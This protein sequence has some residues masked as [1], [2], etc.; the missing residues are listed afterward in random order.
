MEF[1][2]WFCLLLIVYCYFGYPLFLLLVSKFT[3]KPVDKK[4]IM[5]KVSIVLSVWNEQDVIRRKLSNLMAL[6]YPADSYEIIVGSDGSDDNTN[7]IVRSFN[8]E[9]IRFVERA[10]RRGKMIVLNELVSLARH[11]IIVFN[12]ARQELPP[13]TIHKLVANFADS[14]VGCVSGELVFRKKEGATAQGINLYWE[15]EKFMRYHEAKIHSMLGATGAIYAIRKSLY[16]PVPKDVVLDDMYIPFRIIEQ[17]FRAVFEPLAKAYDDVAENPK[18]EARR[19]NRTLFGNFQIFQL[20]P[21]MFNPFESHIAIQ[22]FSHKFLRIAAPFLMVFLILL[23][24]TL[25]GRTFY[26]WTMF[27]QLLFYSMAVIGLLTK[28]MANKTFRPLTKIC[29]VPYVFCLLN[30][31][32]FVGFWRFLTSKQQIT[33]EKARLS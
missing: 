18:E 28:D 7:E 9:R 14:S 8:D 24:L 17:G 23:N 19:K 11:E 6:D 12:D 10:E 21:N 32:V 26:V 1:L 25:L 15:Y 27:A 22:L 3:H 4:P 33:W 2:F 29:Y 30:F 20:F 13:D 31:S 5:P 16:H